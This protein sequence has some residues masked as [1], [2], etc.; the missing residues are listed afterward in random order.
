MLFLIFAIALC[1]LEKV[2]FKETEERKE[3]D[4]TYINR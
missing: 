3:I 2:E 4:M 1:V